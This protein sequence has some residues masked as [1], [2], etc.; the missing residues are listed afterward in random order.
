MELEYNDDLD[1][2]DDLDL[3][4]LITSDSSTT[5]KY[6]V[7]EGSNKEYYAINVAKVIEVLVYKD[8]KMAKNG[9]SESIIRAT[10]QIRD[11]MA[12]IINFDQ[13][14]GNEVLDDSEYE[15]VI[16]AGFGG[17]NL[18]IMIKSVEYIVSIDSKDMK[19][20]SMNNPKTNFISD[21]KLNGEHKLCTVF[22]CD[23][24]L[25]DTFEDVGKK[26]NLEKIEYK[27]NINSDKLVLFAD[28]SRFIRITV[29]K[30]LEKLE[31]RYKIF[32]NGLALLNEIKTLNPS[33]IGLVITDLEMP[34]MDGNELV[35]S[36]NELDGYEAISIIVHTNMSNFIM[37]SSL[38]KLGV[39]EVIAKI[40]MNQLSKGISK[41]FIP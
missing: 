32:D 13:W 9:S 31:L 7:F 1:N 4:E 12:T 41:Y 5:N 25:L 18:A 16:L 3:L 2:N 33:D 20:N 35:K 11:E 21:I 36:I 10:A 28:D 38:T 22:D 39:D 19:D 37:K 14:F 8:L 34:I 40:D 29:Q 26:N 30:L 24:L 23:K 6:L 17:Y 15:Y 27:K